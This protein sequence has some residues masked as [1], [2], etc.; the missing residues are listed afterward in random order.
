[1]AQVLGKGSV[2]TEFRDELNAH[3]HSYRSSADVVIRQ[4]GQIFR[5]AH[6][7]MAG[8]VHGYWIGNKRAYRN[9]YTPRIA[10]QNAL[11]SEPDVLRVRNSV[12]DRG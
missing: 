12:D 3:R 2:T 11:L 1:M 4:D 5:R 9:V 10:C 6:R 7:M 8:A